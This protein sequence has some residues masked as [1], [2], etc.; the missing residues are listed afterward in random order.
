VVAAPDGRASVNPTGNSGLATAG[1]GD[2]LSGIIAGFMAQG[3][4]PFDAARL[5]VYVHGLT[6]DVL[7]GEIGEHGLIA[8][9]LLQMVPGVIKNLLI[10]GAGEPANIVRLY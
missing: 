10:G 8:G 7:A 4:S 2:V 5:G 3:L 9:D 1:S 6:A